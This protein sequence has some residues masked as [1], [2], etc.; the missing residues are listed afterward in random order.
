MTTIPTLTKHET[1]RSLFPALETGVYLNVG[2]YGIM[3][4]PALSS[5]LELVE[6][7]ERFGLFSTSGV[8]QKAEA[9]RVAL[10]QL[11]GC[12][13]TQITFTGNATD[14]TNLVLAGLTWQAGDEVIVTDEEH[15]AINHPLLY[16]QRSKGIRMRRIKVSP[17]PDVMRQHCADV[18]SERTRLLAFSHV[19]CETGTRLPAAEMCLWAAERG[20][21]TLVDG[22]QSLGVFKTH[23]DDIGCDFYTGN[24]HKWLSGPKGTGIFYT[25]PARLLELSPAHVGAGSLEHANVDSG[26]ADLWTSGRRFEFGT[27]A[28]S[29]YAGLGY[30]LAWLEN[31]GWDNIEQYIAHLSNYLKTKI[32]AR[33]YLHLLTPQPF[34]QSSGLTTFVMDAWDAGKL[35]QELMRRARVRVR[36]IPHYNAIRIST[37]YFNNEA[38]VDMLIDT[39]DAIE[40]EK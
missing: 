14:G 18:A 28:T 17:E 37:T 29:L 40:N 7:Y 38:D 21:L 23:I 35:S 12:E 1:V 2:T 16:L 22:A 9:A 20:I 10:S 19:T 36:V 33:S 24:G 8:H 3:P 5:F 26:Q 15:E 39:L 30:S 27:R 34:A 6:E 31:L 11:L 4:A 25:S 13:A 32:L